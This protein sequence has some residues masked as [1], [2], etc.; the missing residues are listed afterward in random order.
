MAMHVVFAPDWR[1][2]NLYQSLL[3]SALEDRGVKVSFLS[4]YSRGF[5]LF[6]GLSKSEATVIHLHWP[7]AY[8]PETSFLLHRLLREWRFPFDLGAACRPRALVATAHNLL[9]HWGLGRATYR[10]NMA[11][12]YRQADRVIAHSHAAAGALRNTFGV[13]AEAIRVI[14]HGDLSSAT[15]ALPKRHDARAALGIST[16]QRLVLMFGAVSR[17]KGIEDAIAYWRDGNIS[18]RLVV[19]GKAESPEYADHLTALAEGDLRIQLHVDRFLDDLE[20]NRWLAAADVCLFNYRGILTSG[21][22]IQARALGIPIL[23]PAHLDLVDLGEPDSRVIRYSRFDHHFGKALDQALSTPPDHAS[24][25][26]FRESI[27]WEQ[28]ASAHIQVYQ[29][30]LTPS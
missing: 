30:A 14:P 29:E 16:E 10:R 23:F 24:A 19:A 18:S 20:L 21:S 12:T 11:V 6:R 28:I 26:R 13:I 4:G 22:A 5:P 1:E 3:A 8:F 25:G 17:Y 27:R 7:E 9:P 15:D 2:G